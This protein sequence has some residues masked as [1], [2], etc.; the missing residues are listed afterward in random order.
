MQLLL[1]KLL[2]FS[3][4]YCILVLFN[5]SA[6]CQ[7][8]R[9][10]EKKHLP[11]QTR[12]RGHP[13]ERDRN[14]AFSALLPPDAAGLDLGRKRR[15]PPDR[16]GVQLADLPEQHHDVHAGGR[17]E[18]S[19][20]HCG[21]GRPCGSG[22]HCGGAAVHQCPDPLFWAISSALSCRWP[23]CCSSSSSC[24]PTHPRC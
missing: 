7:N 22:A 16:H 14:Q 8:I 24:T 12:K 21:A 13:Y 20:C 15:H 18:G 2:S 17:C 4:K 5:A 6:A 1:A 23:W 10:F 19:P 11:I 9:I 3:G